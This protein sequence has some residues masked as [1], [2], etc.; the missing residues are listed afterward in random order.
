MNRC[1][2]CTACCEVFAIDEIKK[3]SGSL[4]SNCNGGCSIYDKRPD[5]CKEYKCS[6]LAGGWDETLRPDKCGVIIDN[7]KNGYQAIR[8]KDDVDPIILT[9]IS[10]IE[11]EYKVE[12]KGID[13]RNK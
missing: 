7:S 2:D 13:G 9:Q 12:I 10:F 3:P 11:K 6:W 4:C 1:G 5:P 8:F